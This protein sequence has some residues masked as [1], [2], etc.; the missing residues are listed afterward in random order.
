MTN[1]SPIARATAVTIDKPATST[2]AGLS[3]GWTLGIY[4]ST[5]TGSVE[6]QERLVALVV[7]VTG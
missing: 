2:S 7:H 3:S 1:T 5:A 4:L 6:G